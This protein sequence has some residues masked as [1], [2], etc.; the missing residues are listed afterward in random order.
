MINIASLAGLKVLPLIGIYAVSKACVVQMRKAMA[1]EWGRY[2]INTNALCPGY[3]ETE[4]NRA[5]FATG[6]GPRLIDKLPRKKVGQP[7]YLDATLVMLASG[8]SHLVKGATIA[9]DDGFAL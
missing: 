4:I 8:Q 6:A 5:Y 2:G 7:E 9:A 1:T 3:I